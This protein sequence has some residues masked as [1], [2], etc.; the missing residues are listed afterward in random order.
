MMPRTKGGDIIWYFETDDQKKTGVSAN[1]QEIGIC[2]SKEMLMAT[3][4]MR[5]RLW[6]TAVI[7]K[8]NPSLA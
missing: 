8:W 2:K 5:L 1:P 6:V 3:V 7:L 4:K